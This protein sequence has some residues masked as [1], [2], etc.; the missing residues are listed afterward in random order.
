MKFN[1]IGNLFEI[2]LIWILFFGLWLFMS[3]KLIS[4]IQLPAL[5]KDT[6]GQLQNQMQISKTVYINIFIIHLWWLLVT[7]HIFELTFWNITLFKVVP[8]A[9]NVSYEA[10]NCKF[11]WEH[12]RDV[13]KMYGRPCQLQHEIKKRTLYSSFGEWMWK[14]WKRTSSPCT[15]RHPLYWKEERSNTTNA[16]KSMCNC[17]KC[18]MHL[19]KIQFQLSLLCF[20][21]VHYSLYFSY[22]FYFI[23]IL[24]MDIFVSERQ[25]RIT[26]KR[27]VKWAPMPL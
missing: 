14:F 3:L 13:G 5:G 27:N 18:P 1:T 22:I 10:T 16:H 12:K 17:R 11:P 20:I 21:D 4:E 26:L 19:T 6:N 24:Y 23:Y 15:V 9:G 2:I 7:F 25:Q 8:V